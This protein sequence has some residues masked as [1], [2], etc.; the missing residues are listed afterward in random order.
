MNKK[1]IIGIVTL[2]LLS[3]GYLLFAWGQASHQIEME[4]N[5]KC[6]DVQAMA[7]TKYWFNSVDIRRLFNANGMNVSFIR[8]NQITFEDNSI[9][10]LMCTSS[11]NFDNHTDNVE[12]EFVFQSGVVRAK[13]VSTVFTSIFSNNNEAIN[14]NIGYLNGIFNSYKSFIESK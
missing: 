5:Y 6:T 8:N 11:S 9:G 12:M 1:K 4:I 2:L 7:W 13:F 10:I 3:G 14:S